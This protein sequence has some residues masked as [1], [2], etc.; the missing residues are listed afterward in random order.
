MYMF[1][2]KNKK[3]VYHFRDIK[4]LFGYKYFGIFS[5]DLGLLTIEQC[6]F[7]KVGGRLLLLVV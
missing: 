7:N 1:S 4:K 3:N 2:I 6:I 5:T